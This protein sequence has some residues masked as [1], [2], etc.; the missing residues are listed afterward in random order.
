M[1]LG[2]LPGTGYHD[3]AKEMDLIDETKHFHNFL[4]DTKLKWAPDERLWI[5]KAR[6]VY[7]W[8]M[9]VYLEKE[10]SCLYREL[11]ALVESFREDERLDPDM[12]RRM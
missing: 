12:E 11:V 1:S 9:N 10:C 6:C 5:D 2:Y 7:W 3:I 8:W 4:H